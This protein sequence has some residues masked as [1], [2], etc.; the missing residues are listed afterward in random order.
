MNVNCILKNILAERPIP[1]KGV[2][3]ELNI[4]LENGLYEN[5]DFLQLYSKD[6]DF[7][8]LCKNYKKISIRIYKIKLKHLLK[9]CITKV[10]LNVIKELYPNMVVN[11]LINIQPLQL[12]TG[13]IFTL[14]T[15]Y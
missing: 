6:Q 3:K 11:D 13:K 15:K 1:N 9:L 5:I 7:A 10:A 2:Y 4:L 8:Y 14:K 12:N